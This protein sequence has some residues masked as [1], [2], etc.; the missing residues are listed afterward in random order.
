VAIAIL[1]GYVCLATFGKLLSGGK[2]KEETPAAAAPV[3]P[4][5][6]FGSRVIPSIDSDDFSKF[7]E[8]D[9]FLKLLE[10]EKDLT[11]ALEG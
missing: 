2:K 5:T 1:G 9:A 3:T 4:V 7:L 6:T 11:A 10:N 8:T